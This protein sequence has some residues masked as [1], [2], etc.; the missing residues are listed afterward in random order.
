M[1][2]NLNGVKAMY[3]SAIDMLVSSSGFA[4]PC[5]FVYEQGGVKCPNC[6]YDPLSKRSN[7]VY[8]GSGIM[9]FPYG[10]L[11][12]VCAGEGKTTTT[13][14]ETVQLTLVFNQK[15]FMQ[16]GSVS[17]AVGNMQSIS[18]IASYPKIKSADYVIPSGNGISDYRQNSYTRM[19]EPEFVSLGDNRY[20]V[21]N[22]QRGGAE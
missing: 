2:I 20:I 21:T 16:I 4:Q 1:N 18:T 22:W 9:P 11:C 19:S 5:V 6:G 17:T 12:P 15:D 3:N 13:K 14:E 7:G 10:Q 8:N